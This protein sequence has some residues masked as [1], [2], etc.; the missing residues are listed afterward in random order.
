MVQNQHGHNIQFNY[1]KNFR[2]TLIKELKKVGIPT[3][4]YYQ[5]P[6]HLQTAYEKFPKSNC[7]EVSE[8]IS[9]KV[10]SL[11]LNLKLFKTILFKKFLKTI[12]IL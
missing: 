5:K 6:L 1:L 10:L 9:E 8:E 11:P 7:L 3:M 2:E 12:F 4:I